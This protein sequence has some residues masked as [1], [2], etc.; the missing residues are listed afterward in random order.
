M[1]I[2]YRMS[3]LSYRMMSG[4][5]YLPDV[6]LPNI[7]AGKRLVPELLQHDCTP[8][9]LADAASDL[10][11]HPAQLQHLQDRFADMHLSL[12]RDTAALASQAI[13]DMI[14]A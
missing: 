10:L 8:L 3:A 12:R 9:A 13:L 2:G 5:G 11:E 7:L 6:G 14:P 4:R 1:V